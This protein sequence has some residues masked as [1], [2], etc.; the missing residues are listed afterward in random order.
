MPD[1]PAEPDGPEPLISVI[2]PSV[3]GLTALVEC[4][5]CL[6]AQDGAIAA[7]VL[8]VDRCGELVREVLRTRYP[9][10]RV[11]PVE[12]QPSIPAMRALAIAQARG[13]VVAI[14]EDHCMAHPRWYQTIARAHGAGHQAVGGPVENGSTERVV[15]WAVFFCEY[16]R[17][18]TPVPRGVVPEIPGNNSAYD[19]RVLDRLGPELGAEVW[20]SFLHAK[21]RAHGVA[22]YCDPEMIVY[23]KKSFGF[24][25]FLSQRYHYSRSFAGMRMDGAPWWRRAG[26]AGATALLPGLLLGRIATVVIRKGGHGRQFLLSLPSLC[27]FLVSWAIGEG[28]G[29]LFGPGQSLRRVE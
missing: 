6:R 28:I 15:D 7:E 24:G 12:D 8:V 23:H 10:V 17:F 13:R 1:P 27:T 3:N 22:F 21:L 18:M 26:Y 11:F 20:E 5:D 4:L 2:I 25:Y 9:E 16:A 19:R 14:I 29:A